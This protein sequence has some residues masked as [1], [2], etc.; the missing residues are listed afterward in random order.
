MA[1]NRSRLSLFGTVRAAF[2]GPFT[3]TA[4]AVA[5][6]SR[7][8]EDERQAIEARIAGIALPLFLFQSPFTF[9]QV[10]FYWESAPHRTPAEHHVVVKL[11]PETGDRISIGPRGLHRYRGTIRCEIATKEKRGSAFARTIAD[12]IAKQMENAK[13]SAGNSGTISTGIP[14]FESRGVENGWYRATLSVDY[15]RDKVFSS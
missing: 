15:R 6:V 2:F 12:F 13:F 1:R 3:K 5:G 9:H 14:W 7:P 10:K 4:Q 8:F 11:R